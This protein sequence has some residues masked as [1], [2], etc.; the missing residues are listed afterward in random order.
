[1]ASPCIFFLSGLFYLFRSGCFNIV[2]RGTFLAFVALLFKGGGRNDFRFLILKGLNF[3]YA[4]AIKLFML[5]FD[6]SVEPS[7]KFKIL[8]VL[9]FN[10]RVV[11][12]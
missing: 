4:I 8:K 10:V 1:M 2:A 3:M 6:E 11:F 7:E 5:I 9:T 12:L